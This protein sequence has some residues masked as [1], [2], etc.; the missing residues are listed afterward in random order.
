M[1]RRSSRSTKAQTHTPCV[2]YRRF[3]EHRGRST[4]GKRTGEALYPGEESVDE[5]ERRFLEP[6]ARYIAILQQ[7]AME[8]ERQDAGTDPPLKTP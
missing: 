4:A 2:V 3:D 6:V 1:P 7:W 8:R 5:A